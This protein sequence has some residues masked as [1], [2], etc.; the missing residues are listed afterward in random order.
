MESS[1]D[2]GLLWPEASTA[3]SNNAKQQTNVRKVLANRAL[4][5]INLTLCRASPA[6]SSKF[7]ASPTWLRDRFH[8]FVLKS[9]P[10]VT[11]QK[12]NNL[13]QM[14]KGG[15][16]IEYIPPKDPEGPRAFS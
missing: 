15:S 11:N 10:T 2:C 5:G 1:F 14:R 16:W 6:Q 7:C 9:N 13:E 8:G 12:F 4:D 3:G